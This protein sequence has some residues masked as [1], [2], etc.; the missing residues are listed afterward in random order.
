MTA[1]FR[2]ELKYF[3]NYRD[4]YILRSRLSGIL[5]H[6]GNADENGA[7]SIR[8]LYFDDLGNRALFEKQSGVLSRD[9]FRIRL[10]NGASDVI[11]LEKK[12]RRGQYVYKTGCRVNKGWVSRLLDNEITALDVLNK[13]V[14]SVV[15]EFILRVQ[16]S[17][18]RPAVIVDYD[19]EAY[20]SALGNVRITFDMNLR[21]GLSSHNIFD[22][23]IPTIDVL[24]RPV[25]IMEVKYD[26]FLPEYILKALRGVTNTRYAISKYVMCRKYTKTNS[27][28]DN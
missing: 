5:K 17:N 14:E 3:V 12:S 4:Y 27:W 18:L 9:K 21:T 10:Y 26:E 7:Y 28:E 16:Y 11:K 8:S 22:N 13:P 19:R 23:N 1:K 2:H 15:R 20:I 24:E 25:H 6:D